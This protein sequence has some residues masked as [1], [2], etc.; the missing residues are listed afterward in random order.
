MSPK[1]LRPDGSEVWGTFKAD[2]DELQDRGLVAYVHSI[3]DARKSSRCGDNPLMLKAVAVQ[4]K[5]S[6][7][8]VISDDD[9]KL[10]LD[11]N[12]IG[13][14]LDKLNVIFVMGSPPAADSQSK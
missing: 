3:D 14:F 12:K 7:D 11:E 2:Y 6:T 8:P 1:I 5:N 10:L 4:G 13:C 9:G